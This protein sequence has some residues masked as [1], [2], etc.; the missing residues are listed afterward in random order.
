MGFFDKKK[1]EKKDD[2]KEDKKDNKKEKG[3]SVTKNV[4]LTISVPSGHSIS[5]PSGIE[6]SQ[7]LIDELK[8]LALAQFPHEDDEN[9]M[10]TY[11]PVGI[12]YR[13]IKVSKDG[14]EVKVS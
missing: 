7:L 13:L 10:L 6:Q 4:L 3:I 9:I 11:E 12:Y 5:S 2:K 14:K 8:K 1:D